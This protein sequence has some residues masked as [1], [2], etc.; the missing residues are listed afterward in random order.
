MKLKLKKNENRKDIERIRSKG[1][2]YY[3]LEKDFKIRKK[4]YEEFNIFKKRKFEE[5]SFDD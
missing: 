1:N 2:V 4:L 3:D 5:E